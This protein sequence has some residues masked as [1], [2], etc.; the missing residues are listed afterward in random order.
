[1]CSR[2][3]P[4]M[5]P[6]AVTSHPVHF[7]ENMTSPVGQ[8]KLSLQNSQMLN[9]GEQ[10]NGRPLLNNESDNAATR[11]FVWTLY[12][13]SWGEDGPEWFRG[14]LVDM[15]AKYRQKM[16]CYLKRRFGLLQWCQIT[17][18]NLF[19]YGGCMTAITH[20]LCTCTVR[21]HP[22]VISAIKALVKLR[23]KY[24]LM[25]Y[26]PLLP[27]QLCVA[28]LAQ[29]VWE[30]VIQT[31]RYDSCSLGRGADSRGSLTAL[32]LRNTWY[33]HHKLSVWISPLV[34]DAL[35]EIIP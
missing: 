18:F 1:M 14:A 33:S 19:F 16:Y 23:S 25:P 10:R 12:K 32:H 4:L 28:D 3:F 5:Y 7:H 9:E 17:P 24:K 11:V 35:N 29:P 8:Q 13:F 27:A 30:H 31:G 26:F 2:C 6:G 20:G 22:T 34:D 15:E 21:K